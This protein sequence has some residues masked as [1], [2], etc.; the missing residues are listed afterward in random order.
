MPSMATRFPIHTAPEGA[1]HHD[2]KVPIMK[3]LFSLKNMLTPKKSLKDYAWY[4]WY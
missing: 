3:V 1:T 4:I 2:R